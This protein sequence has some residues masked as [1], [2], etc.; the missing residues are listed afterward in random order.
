MNREEYRR[1][2]VAKQEKMRKLGI[3]EVHKQGVIASYN[4]VSWKLKE[5]NLTPY[6]RLKLEEEQ[7]KLKKELKELNLI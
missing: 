3:L 7:K 6:Q 5:K 2:V 4:I 1:Q